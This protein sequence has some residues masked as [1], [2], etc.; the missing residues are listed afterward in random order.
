[1]SVLH[2]KQ[3]AFHTSS[4]ASFWLTC[5]STVIDFLPDILHAVRA[6]FDQV[7]RRSRKGCNNRSETIFD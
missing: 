4:E 5:F 2:I 3:C 6:A 1:M 7:S